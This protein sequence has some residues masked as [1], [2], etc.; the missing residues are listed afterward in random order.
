MPFSALQYSHQWLAQFQPPPGATAAVD[1]TVGNGHDT[2]FLAQWLGPEGVVHGFD[3]QE[4]AL[5]AARQ[6]CDTTPTPRAAIRWH[7]CGHE[8]ADEVLDR[9]QAPPLAAVM[10]NLGYHPGGDKSIITRPATT[11]RALEILSARLAL[12]GVMTITAY[13]GHPGGREETEAVLAWAAAAH[14]AHFHIAHH[15]PLNQGP[16]PELITLER[17]A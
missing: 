15:R 13:P 14:P 3:I 17:L 9:E 6:R 8:R 11:V 10:F 12:G 4:A 5:A 1:A 2:L 16:R 7:L